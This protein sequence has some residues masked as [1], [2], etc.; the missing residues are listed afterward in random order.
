VDSGHVIQSG[1]T[2]YT[3]EEM[4][5]LRDTVKVYLPNVALR[6]VKED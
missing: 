4:E 6:G 5:K 1:F 3:K 2:A